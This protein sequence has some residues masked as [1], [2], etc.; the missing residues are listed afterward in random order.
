ME[1]VLCVMR[2]AGW[3]RVWEQD[4]ARVSVEGGARIRGWGRSAWCRLAGGRWAPPAKCFRRG[5][6]PSSTIVTMNLTSPDSICVQVALR[7][8]QK[9]LDKL[10]NSPAAPPHSPLLPATA[11]AEGA[12]GRPRSA[13]STE[14]ERGLDLVPEEGRRSPQPYLPP[15]AAPSTSDVA[16]QTPRPPSGSSSSRPGSAANGNAA[17]AAPTTP[18]GAGPD[19]A[20]LARLQMLEGALRQATADYQMLLGGGVGGGGGAW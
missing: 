15:P 6:H 8:A 1:L 20:T 14:E 17:A 12:V 11:A 13:P 2:E 7:A 5:P 10:A 3:Q 4:D 9:E 16:T 18:A 19:A